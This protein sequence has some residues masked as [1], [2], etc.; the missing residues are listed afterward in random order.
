MSHGSGSSSG[1]SVEVN[2]IPMIDIVIQLITFFLMLV[3]FDES[4]ND[5]RVRLPIADLAKPSEMEVEEMLILNVN[6]AGEVNVGIGGDVVL[7]VDSDAFRQHM[8]KEARATEKSMQQAKRDIKKVAGRP[9]LWT[10]VMIRAD[11]DVEYE[12][13]QRM[14]RVCQ[15]QGFTKFALRASPEP[16]KM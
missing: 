5:E 14:M 4:N 16:K 10:T 2:L 15:D 6:R 11:R 8:I 9:Q 13:I 3:N 12:R 7:D 1:N